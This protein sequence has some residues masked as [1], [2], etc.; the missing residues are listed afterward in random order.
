MRIFSSLKNTTSIKILVKYLFLS[1]VYYL[2]KKIKSIS[3]LQSYI[4]IR[5]EYKL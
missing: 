4:N 1:F 5:D 3:I 2:V